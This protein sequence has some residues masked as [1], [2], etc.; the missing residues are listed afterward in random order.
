MCH[1]FIQCPTA[2]TFAGPLHMQ[3]Y[4]AVQS[5]NSRPPPAWI[6]KSYFFHAVV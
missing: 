1:N 5:Q 2:M 6:T 4:F 3:A